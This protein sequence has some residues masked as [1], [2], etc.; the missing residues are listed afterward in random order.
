MR[1]RQICLVAENLQSSLE[2][3]ADLLASPVIYRD[4][5]VAHFGLE[6][7]L[8]MTGGDFVEVV[9]PLADAEDTAAGRHLARCGDSFYMAIFQCADANSHIRHIK[10]NGGRG[11]FEID[12]GGVRATHFH[13]KDF[14]GAIVSVDSMGRDDWQSPRAY[15][16]WAKWPRE[17]APLGVINTSVGALAGLRVS[18]PARPDMRNNPDLQNRWAHFLQRPSQADRLLFDG[19]EIIFQ[20]ADTPR[21]AISD[22]Y[23]HAGRDNVNDIHA[24]AERLGLSMQNGGFSFGGVIWHFGADPTAPEGAV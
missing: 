8:I 22:I 20:Q 18:T 10:N 13:P 2:I 5:E 19:A 9:S 1:L 14:G 16:E 11:V 15:W 4:P 12:A 24:R 7:G 3:L 21:A 17:D 23:L 6:N